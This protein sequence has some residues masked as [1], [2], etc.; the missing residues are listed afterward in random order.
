MIGP[1]QTGFEIFKG[2]L[3]QAAPILRHRKAVLPLLYTFLSVIM[4]VPPLETGGGSPRPS[5]DCLI[6]LHFAS[7]RRGQSSASKECCPLIR[8]VELEGQNAIVER[9]F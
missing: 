4:C 7:P 1:A 3:P 9:H 6:G 8:F 5:K 2:K